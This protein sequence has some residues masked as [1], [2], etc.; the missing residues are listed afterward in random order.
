MMP[1]TKPTVCSQPG[2]KQSF[3]LGKPK[4]MC[5]GQPLGTPEER[6]GEWERGKKLTTVLTDVLYRWIYCRLRPALE[7][8]QPLRGEKEEG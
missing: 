8:L 3:T 1:Q 6:T 2:L 5:S 4:H 7:N